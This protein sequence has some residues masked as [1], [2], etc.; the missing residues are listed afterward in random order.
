MLEVLTRS[1][2]G[3]DAEANVDDRQARL[4]SFSLGKNY[5]N[6]LPLQLFGYNHGIMTF[7]MQP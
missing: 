1:R 4:I 7:S 5:A 3:C 2:K 6:Q